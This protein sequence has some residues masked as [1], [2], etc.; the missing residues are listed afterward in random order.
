M[1]T[2]VVNYAE[3]FGFL[4][5]LHARQFTCVVPDYTC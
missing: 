1:R 4:L 3:G 5:M 2:K